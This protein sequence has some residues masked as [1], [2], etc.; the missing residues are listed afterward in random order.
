MEYGG[1]Q[2]G[3]RSRMRNNNP[4]YFYNCLT[5]PQTGLRVGVVMW[6]A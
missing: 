5:R 6:E 2:I 1:C 4:P 3:S